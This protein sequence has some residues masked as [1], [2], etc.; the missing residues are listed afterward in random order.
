MSNFRYGKPWVE[1]I[2]ILL[3]YSKLS[4]VCF[5]RLFLLESS[6]LSPLELLYDHNKTGS[7]LNLA[8]KYALT[9]ICTHNLFREANSS[10]IKKCLKKLV[11]FEKR[12]ATSP[13]VTVFRMDS[14]GRSLSHLLH[15]LNDA[16]RSHECTSYFTTPLH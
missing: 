9:L 14:N 11:H 10:L 7:R 4:F 15:L 16:I 6:F 1:F 8:R 5:I 3:V 2:I 12:I 13:F